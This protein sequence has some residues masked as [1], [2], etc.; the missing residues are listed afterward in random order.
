MPEYPPDVTHR[1]TKAL[2]QIGGSGLAHDL[3]R[4]MG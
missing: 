3:D 1:T 2:Q 4:D